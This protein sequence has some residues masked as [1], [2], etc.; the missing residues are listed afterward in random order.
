MVAGNHQVICITHLPQV[1]AW[2]D[3]HLLVKKDQTGTYTESS[4][5]ELNSE[6]RIREIAR[7]LAG[8]EDSQ[9]ALQ[10]AAELLDITAKSVIS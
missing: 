2:A 9:S 7:M 4:V 10:H 1:A 6:D 3:T 8:Q 5:T